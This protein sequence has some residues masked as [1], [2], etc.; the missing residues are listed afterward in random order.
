MN[1]RAASVAAP[2]RLA[3]APYLELT[4]PRLSLFVLVVVFLSGWMAAGGAYAVVWHAV[5][6]TGL[7]A[8]GA[9][10]L[11]M[12]FERRH[13]ANMRRTAGRPLP[14]GRLTPREVLGF[15][16]LCTVAGVTWLALAT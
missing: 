15:G 16:V 9:N 12:Y 4:K 14:S 1:T 6:A 8:G 11:N 7:V 3:L 2:R 10:A 13:D 5:L